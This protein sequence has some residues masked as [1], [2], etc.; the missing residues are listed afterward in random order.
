MKK[1]TILISVAITLLT[2]AILF[3]QTIPQT[4]NYQGVLKDASGVVVTNGDYN[5]TFKLYDV[6]TSGT[7]LWSETKLIN[8]VDGIINTQIGSVNPITLPFDEGYWLGVTVSTGNEMAPRIKLTSVPYSLMTMNVMDESITTSKLQDGSVTVNKLS[9]N[10]I[11]TH[12]IIDGTITATDIGDNQVIKKVNGIR[13]SVNLVAGSNISITPSGNNLTISSSGGIGGGDITAVTAG[14]GLTGGGTVGDITLSIPDDAITNAMLQTNSVMTQQIL[15]GTITIN[16]L[17]DNSVTS[18]KVVDGTLTSADILDGTI[19]TSD[20]ADNSISTVKIL[21]GTITTMDLATGSVTADDIATDAVTTSEILNGTITA[22]DIGNTQVVKSLNTLKDNVTLVAGSNIAITPSGQNLTISSTSSGLGGSGTANYLPIFTNTTTLG[23]SKV[24]QDANGFVQI[25]NNGSN[26]LLTLSAN[27]N[28]NEGGQID[29]NAAGSFTKWYQDVYQSNMRLRTNSADTNYVEIVNKG[30]G[31]T[32]LTVE[33]N[34]GINTTTPTAL[35]DVQG[36]TISSGNGRGIN[37]IAESTSYGGGGDI[38]LNSG[39]GEGGQAGGIIQIEGANLANGK[40]GDITIRSGGGREGGGNID[41]ITGN[42]QAGSGYINIETT[43]GGNGG[44]G[45]IT[46][47]TGNGPEASAGSIKIYTGSTTGSPGANFISL[48]TGS[49]PYGDNSIYL[50]TGGIDMTGKSDIFLEGKNIVLQPDP[51]SLVKINGSGT[52]TG[53]WTQA[54]DKRFKKNVEPIKN[55]V[56]KVQQL[57]GVSYEFKSDE[58]PEK[59][60]ADGKQIGLIAQDVEKIFPELIKTD[61]EGYK[62]IAYQNMVAVLIEAVKEQQKSID[63]LK[64]EVL[65]LKTKLSLEVTAK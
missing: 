23:N 58:F 10:S 31:T 48:E 18:A 13:D 53:T 28:V 5:I 9:D 43:R 61:N 1:F 14:T 59:N 32:G 11:S 15:D 57:N 19:T 49:L 16:D 25:G 26:T 17:G 64:K 60:F 52:Y 2:S 40:A 24:F 27:D 36:G 46:I 20:L 37:L 30:T 41:I 63:E 4:I 21:D 44:S 3:S 50:K 51:D 29:W 62:S 39:S 34:V 42:G 22:T 12:K 38:V 35:L 55:A 6:E 65:E 47:H 8:V 45:P 56:D 33:G 7:E 54:S